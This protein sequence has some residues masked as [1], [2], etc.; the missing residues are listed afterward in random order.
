M[1][2]IIKLEGVGKNLQDHISTGGLDFL[3]TPPDK[4]NHY[5][6]ILPEV[7]TKDT[8]EE[9][10]TKK[11]GPFYALPECET[12][13]FVKTNFTEE[14]DDWPDIQL[15]FSA[16]PENADGG[17]LSKRVIGLTDDY[18]ADV[19]ENIVH[20]NAFAVI[21]LLMR[22][23]SRGEIVLK[24]KDPYNPPLIYPNYFKDPYD[25]KVLVSI[26]GSV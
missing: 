8:V 10:V 17:I 12:M 19:Y 15:F 13:A 6:F 21:P 4:N 18:Y 26:Q 11:Q 23:R 1:Q 22:P 24:N 14:D 25:L 9:F 16:A 2:P 5:T 20:K 3:Y 7:F